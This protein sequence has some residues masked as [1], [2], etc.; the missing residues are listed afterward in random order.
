MRGP[1]VIDGIVVDGKVVA[2]SFACQLS[3]CKGACCSIPGGRG[4]PLLNSEIDEIKEALPFILPYLDKR[5]QTEIKEN[6]FF[7]GALNDL[8]TTCIDERDCV[9]VYHENGISK[10]AIEKAYIDGKTRFRKP[11]SCHL[12]PIR[13]INFGG[14]VLKYHEIIECASAREY[15]NKQNVVVA[16]FVKDGLIRAFGN[17]WYRKLQKEVKKVKGKETKIKET[18]RV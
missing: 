7:E 15:G 6:G 12:Y 5:N 9:F 8:A 1:L 16:E 13:V 4:A 2:Q 17:E 11:I 10:C 18:A 14:P 3:I